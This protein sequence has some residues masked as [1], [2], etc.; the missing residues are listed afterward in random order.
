M[1]AG[2]QVDFGRLSAVGT[3]P[4][5]PHTLLGSTM[6]CDWKLNPTFAGNEIKR[7]LLLGRK[8]MTNLDSIFRLTLSILHNACLAP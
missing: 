6:L 2:I 4:S 1:I 7:C 3:S 8:V 5:R